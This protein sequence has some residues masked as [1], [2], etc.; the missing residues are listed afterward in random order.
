MI[1]SWSPNTIE[2]PEPATPRRACNEGFHTVATASSDGFTDVGDFTPS[3]SLCSTPPQTDSEANMPILTPTTTNRS[4]TPTDEADD[5]DSTPTSYTVRSPD[6]RYASNMSIY[7]GLYRGVQTAVDNSKDSSN[8]EMSNTLDFTSKP[9]RDAIHASPS[10]P[11]QTF[12]FTSPPVPSDFTYK[13]GRDATHASSSSTARTFNFCDVPS[14]SKPHHRHER[15][16]CEKLRSG[17]TFTRCTLSSCSG[18]NLTL[19]DCTAS[20]CNI[21]KSHLNN[22][23][24]RSCSISRSDIIGAKLNSCNLNDCTQSGCTVRSC[25]TN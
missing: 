21:S 12:N 22:G 24:Y 9:S 8:E 16:I 10:S 17:D 14:T 7:G 20:S 19:E 15:L 13:S 23:S 11:A 1:K 2:N 18:S 25:T 6:G 5:H 3:A 4:S